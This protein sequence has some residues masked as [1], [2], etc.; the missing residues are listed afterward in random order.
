MSGSNR[1]R[2]LIIAGFS[3]SLINFRGPLLRAMRE[4]GWEVE[5][6]APRLSRDR[7]TKSQLNEM[8]IATHDV[9]L[10]RTGMNPLADARLLLALIRLLRLRRPQVVL[11]YT[12]KAVIFGLMAAA[13][14]R[15][16]RRF[17][18]ITGVG[19]AFTGAATGRRRVARAVSQSLYK[20]SLKH[21]DKLFFQNPDDLELF[22]E[23]ALFPPKVPAIVV[24]GSGVDLERFRPAPLPSGP[25]RFLLIARLLSAKG[26]REYAAAA[27]L[28]R[29]RYKDVEFDL[30]GGADPN[31]DVI[32]LT[33][34]ESWQRRGILTWHGEA[35]DVRSYIARSHVYVLPSYREGTPRSVLEAM[36]MGRPV[37]TT[38]TAGCRETV[39]EGVNGFLVP[40]GS[41]EPL[42]QA[43]ERF[44]TRPELIGQLGAQSRSIAENRYDVR[45]VN[46]RLLREMELA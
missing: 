37:I 11:A 27:S 41:V 20:V 19:Y 7:G 42:A 8:G 17:A 43:M 4:R 29:Q 10:G 5:A 12:M 24:N 25:M 21:A 32:A 9:P 18:I 1:G 6:A 35:D 15:V 34:I 44:V 30:V 31:P 38:D 2:V 16:P 3:A 33:E 40:V 46:A 23:L 45:E 13:I 28:I 22:R 39:I 26:V 14:A 36:A